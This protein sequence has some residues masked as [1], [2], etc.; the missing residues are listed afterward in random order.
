MTLG[1]GIKMRRERYDLG[2]GHPVTLGIDSSLRASTVKREERI[3]GKGPRTTEESRSFGE[4]PGRDG[5]WRDP[6]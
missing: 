5:M 1:W 6:E 2:W 4:H 3:L